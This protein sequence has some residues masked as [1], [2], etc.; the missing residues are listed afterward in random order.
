[1]L[2]RAGYRLHIDGKSD[3]AS[4]WVGPVVWCRWWIEWGPERTLVAHHISTRA[5]QM[6]IS[7]SELFECDRLDTTGTSPKPCLWYQMMI[8]V[9]EVS[10]DGQ[11]YQMQ[12]WDRVERVLL[13]HEWRLPEGGHF[14]H[15]GE[16]SQ[17]CAVDDMLIEYETS[18][19]LRTPFGVADLRQHWIRQ[20][21]VAA[22]HYMIQCWIMQHI[23]YR[24]TS[25]CI[26]KC[27][28]IHTGVL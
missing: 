1:M 5:A 24:N 9:Y 19:S 2:N 6:L 27:R 17:C 15:V 12:H 20:C 8:P 16:L 4:W 22:K 10:A 11:S 26:L 7:W 13:P 25:P 3:H 18:R 14:E 23:F 28:D 21:V